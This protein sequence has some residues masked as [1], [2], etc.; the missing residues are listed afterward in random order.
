MDKINRF[1]CSERNDSEMKW[2]IHNKI[3]FKIRG[4]LKK[5]EDCLRYIIFKNFKTFKNSENISQ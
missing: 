3:G 5:T 4:G 2:K 1:L